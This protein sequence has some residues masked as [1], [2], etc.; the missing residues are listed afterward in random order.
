MRGIIGFVTMCV[1]GYFM[2]HVVLACGVSC[3][4]QPEFNLLVGLVLVAASF[5]VTYVTATR[6]PNRSRLTSEEVAEGIGHEMAV[7][8]AEKAI[9]TPRT[10]KKVDKFLSSAAVK[11]YCSRFILE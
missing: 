1:V 6:W 11:E 3:D 8:M 10:G 9:N 4:F 2:P 5:S 7:L